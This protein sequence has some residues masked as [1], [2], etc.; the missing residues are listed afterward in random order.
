[1]QPE[2]VAPSHPARYADLFALP[3][4]QV[5]EIIAG[6]LYAHPRP[7]PRHARASSALGIKI[8]APFDQGNG[9][10]GGW[11]LLD[12]PELHLHG[13]ILVPDL[14]GWRRDRLPKLPDTAWFELPPDWVC[15]ILSP[16]T[17]R[18]DRMLK[19]PRYATAGVSYCW[20]I[21]PD[22]RTLE[23]FALKDGQWVSL[24]SLVGDAEV[25][26]APFDAIYFAL[27]ALWAD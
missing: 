18:A 27:G 7:G 10:P 25:S 22:T 1:M 20:Q 5:G 16:A 3:E 23:A 17:A 11:W 24:T 6:E 2:P 26:V 4:H 14:A 12:E 19:M 8:G 21:D 9:G 15:E 13:D